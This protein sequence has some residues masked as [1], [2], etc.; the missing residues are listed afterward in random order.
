LLLPL[1]AHMRSAMSLVDTSI[2]MLGSPR[3][4]SSQADLIARMLALAGD[5]LAKAEPSMERFQ[6][7]PLPEPHPLVRGLAEVRLYMAKAA[8]MAPAA[9]AS[10][11][12]AL[13]M[14]QLLD[15]LPAGGGGAGGK[16]AA[17]KAAGGAAG[18]TGGAGKGKAKKKAGG[19]K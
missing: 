3:F 12:C 9:A 18:S 2:R 5:L 1:Q 16:A 4:A 13:N 17:G 7:W 19:K 10:S 15:F 6:Q 14:D 8:E 11:A